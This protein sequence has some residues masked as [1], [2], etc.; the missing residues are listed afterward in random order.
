MDGEVVGILVFGAAAALWLLLPFFD[1]MGQ[2]RGR[3]FIMGA[4]A[5]L[6]CYILA[7]TAYGYLAK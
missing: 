6:L 3:R 5:F 7:M 4:G 2:G 1:Q